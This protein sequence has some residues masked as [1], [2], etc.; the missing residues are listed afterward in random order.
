MELV[1]IIIV[2]GIVAAVAIPKM[3]N[4]TE[5]SRITATQS[6]MQTLKRAIIGNALAVAAGRYTNKGFEGD[7][8]HTPVSLA[9]LGIK[10]D[11]VSAYNK[12]T[13]LGWNGPYIDISGNEYMSDAW[14]SNYIYDRSN[15]RLI[16]LGGADSIIVTF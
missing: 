7:V 16:S 15:R 11:S 8:G 2:L 13:R 6:E 4:I 12:F 3:G 9:E 5:S 10:P 1:I 14:G